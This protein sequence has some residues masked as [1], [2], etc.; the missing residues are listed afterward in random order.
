MATITYTQRH[1]HTWSC[2]D[3]LCA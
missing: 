3:I 2:C 1:T